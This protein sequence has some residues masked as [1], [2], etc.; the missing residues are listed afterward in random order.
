[1]GER[2]VGLFDFAENI[3]GQVRDA[4]TL[5]KRRIPFPFRARRSVKNDNLIIL[6]LREG[7]GI[8]ETE[9]TDEKNC[10]PALFFSSPLYLR[11]PTRNWEPEPKKKKPSNNSALPTGLQFAKSY[12]P[13]TPT[14]I[15]RSSAEKRTG[16][17]TRSESAIRAWQLKVDYRAA[18]R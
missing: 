11:A 10:Y 16:N 3:T 7:K 17:L 6:I 15:N 9:I 1:V 5:F 12:R 18:C 14:K 13:A 8:R 2:R 4:P